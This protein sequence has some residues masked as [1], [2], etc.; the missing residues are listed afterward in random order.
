MNVDSTILGVGFDIQNCE[1]VFCDLGQLGLKGTEKMFL[2]KEPN[3]MPGTSAL[4]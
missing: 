2:S 1:I 3:V 4:I